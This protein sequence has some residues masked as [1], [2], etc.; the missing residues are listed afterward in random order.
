MVSSERIRVQHKYRIDLFEP[1]LCHVSGFALK[2]TY[3]EWIKALNATVDSPLSPCT[4]ILRSTMGIP[5]SHI[6][7]ECLT[8]GQAL[9][10]IDFHEHWWIQDRH[11]EF[12]EPTY[13]INNDST[14]L[15][16]LLQSLTQMYKF[17][18]PHQQAIAYAQLE[19]LLQSPSVVP[20]NPVISKPRGR[21]ARAKNKSQKSTARDPFAF[22]LVEKRLRQCDLCQQ[23]G[24]NCRTCPN[25]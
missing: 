22:E 12:L 4:R 9:Q 11:L 3:D 24:H 5:C 18:S 16:P 17:W 7:S 10:Q 8:T 6:I 25:A 20:K 21:P 23:T 15:Q 1:L 14:D 2:K 19:E 13:P